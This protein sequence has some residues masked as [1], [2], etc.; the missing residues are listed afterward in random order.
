MNSLYKPLLDELC[1]YYPIE[2]VAFFK[3]KQGISLVCDSF[4][5]QKEKRKKKVHKHHQ[6]Y[7][8]LGQRKELKSENFR[9]MLNFQNVFD[10]DGF[11]QKEESFF[12]DDN[13]SK[14]GFMSLCDD[15]KQ[16]K[17]DED[18]SDINEIDVNIDPVAAA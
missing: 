15:G 10:E 14:S 1:K 6:K 5:L 16:N 3:T 9:R 18:I 4:W 13:S 11:D 12:S 8:C 2:F 7:L 17:E